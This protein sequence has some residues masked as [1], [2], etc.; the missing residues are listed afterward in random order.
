VQRFLVVLILCL[1]GFP[2]IAAAERLHLITCSMVR[3][4]VANVGVDQ[5]RAVGIAHGMTPAQERQARRCLE[6]AAKP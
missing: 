5:A 1:G 2:N 4:Y 6:E 3:A